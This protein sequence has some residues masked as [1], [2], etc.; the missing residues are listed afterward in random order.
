MIVKRNRKGKSVTESSQ[1]EKRIVRRSRGEDAAPSITRPT[2]LP[3]RASNPTRGAVVR[4]HSPTVGGGVQPRRRAMPLPRPGI[5]NPFRRWHAVVGLTSLSLAGAVYGGVLIWRSTLLDVAHLEVT[6]NQRVETQTVVE[7][8][9]ILGAN[10]VTADLA[11]VERSLYELPLVASVR[12]ERD[13][14]NTVRLIIEERKG[15]GTWQ[16]GGISYTI[17]REGVVL[18]TIPPSQGSPVIRSAD[19]YTLR[20][21]DRVNYQAVDAAAEIYDRLPRQLGTTVSEVAFVRGKGVTVVTADGQTALLGDSSSIGY[22]LAVWAA[23]ATE[24]Q[25]QRISYT[26]IDLRYGNRP[27]VQ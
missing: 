23:M 27:V 3:I 14:P 4:R 24:A 5:H 19:T 17:D 26:S 13:F 16:Q 9:N 10:I 20:I 1:S 6:G 21:G 11:R 7:R 15:W 12:V 22:K 2:P 8:A 18:G 25:K